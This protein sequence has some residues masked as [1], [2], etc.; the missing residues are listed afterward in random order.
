MKKTICFFILVICCCYVSAQQKSQY[1]QYV[2]NNYL[3]NP[4]FAG[5]DNY[6]DIKIGHRSQWTGL[7][8]APK[9]NYITIN[10]PIG[11]TNLI[12]GDTSKV[13]SNLFS[14]NS[15]LLKPHHGVGFLFMNDKVGLIN[16]TNL[17]LSYSY[18]LK[19]NNEYNL[20]TG[21]TFG[22]NHTS[23]NTALIIIENPSD[24]AIQ[25]SNNKIWKP[26]F[27]LGVLLYKNNFYAG[28][29][30]QQLITQTYFNSNS[31]ANKSKTVPHFFFNLGYKLSF[32]QDFIFS[33]S[34]LLKVIKPVPISYDV[35]LKLAFKNKLWLGASYRRDDSFGILTGLAISR[36]F[37]FG[38]AYDFTTSG[39]NRVS[40]G[41][42]EIVF[43]MILNKFENEKKN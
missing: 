7:Q 10:T 39:L 13:L 35:N 38:Y 30:A 36:R 2:F 12:Q 32:A 40:G 28:I 8:G 34:L 11:K 15:L 29:S 9:T 31:L 17:H 27:T 18:H 37:N 3:L 6:T 22:L 41:S 42:H 16:Q 1:T 23:L 24:I 4:A 33:P 21:L 43:G 20:A 19:L 26:D 5:I 14:P 25:N